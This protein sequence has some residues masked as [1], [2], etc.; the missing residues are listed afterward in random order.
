MVRITWPLRTSSQPHFFCD[1]LR[2]L[3]W[4]EQHSYVGPSSDLTCCLLA[5]SLIHLAHLLG[6]CCSEIW[7]TYRQR[8]P[9]LLTLNGGNYMVKP[10][11]LHP[12]CFLLFHSGDIIHLRIF[13]QHTIILNSVDVVQDL[14][15]R[16]S[17]IYSDRP[18][19]PMINLWGIFS[20]F[21]AELNMSIEWSGISTLGWNLTAHSG[22]HID[23]CLIKHLNHR[24]QPITGRF[25]PGKL[26]TYS[27]VFWQ[28]L[29]TW[30]TIIE[31]NLLSPCLVLDYSFLSVSQQLSS[32]P[33]CTD[34]TLHPRETTSW[35]LQ[36]LQLQNCLN[37]SFQVQMQ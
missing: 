20:S 16:R 13:G 7:A 3:L 11:K 18:D 9:G 12:R 2:F 24:L 26:M 21:D 35:H 30:G 17:H 27:T 15:E 14:I 22:K 1:W 32:C 6:T 19:V 31:R 8:N 33:L 28:V 4:L 25:K 10:V 5:G 29:R 37:P 34:T 23:G 36:K